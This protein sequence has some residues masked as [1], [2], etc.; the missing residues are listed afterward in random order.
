MSKDQ[1][2]IAL[3]LKRRRDY[4]L[5]KKHKQHQPIARVVGAIQP[6]EKRK[7]HDS[8]HSMLITTSKSL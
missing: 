7:C 5:L 6:L 4:L 2:P 8:S 1:T 3:Y